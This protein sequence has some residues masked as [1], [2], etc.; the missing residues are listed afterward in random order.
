MNFVTWL[1]AICLSHPHPRRLRPVPARMIGRHYCNR[2]KP[3]CVRR[4]SRRSLKWLKKSGR[5]TKTSHS[6]LVVPKE[7]D[8]LLA[9]LTQKLRNLANKL[10]MR[11]A[12]EQ[13]GRQARILRAVLSLHPMLKALLL[14]QGGFI[15][16][17][18]KIT[19][20]HTFR[21]A[22]MRRVTA[23]INAIHQALE[24]WPDFT[25]EVLNSLPVNPQSPDDSHGTEA[26]TAILMVVNSCAAFD[27]NGYAVRSSQL[28]SALHAEGINTYFCTRLGYPWDMLGR[29]SAP[30]ANSI[31]SSE[32]Q[33]TLQHDDLWRVGEADPVYWQAYA[34][35][36]VDTVS[37]LKPAPRV[38]HAHSKYSNGIAAALAGRALGLP[39]IYEMRGL[40]HLTRAQREPTFMGSDFFRYE[41]RMELWAAQLADAVVV[42]SSTLKDWLVKQGVTAEKITVIPNAISSVTPAVANRAHTDDSCLKMAFMG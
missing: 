29:E 33:V 9:T 28:A 21:N 25:N 10:I 20:S 7:Y 11:A 34:R 31:E 26:K 36:L 24:H 30:K 35:Y 22:N 40:W 37:Q 8:I 17:A 41:E 1:R 15:N 12:Y 16:K 14:Y 23:R 5:I 27:H 19:D 42:I 38:L 4:L 2:L 18:K 39:V 6:P 13:P 3:L 32:G